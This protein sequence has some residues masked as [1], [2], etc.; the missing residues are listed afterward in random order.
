M[1]LAEAELLFT[2]AEISVALAGFSAIVV[3]FKRRDS[4]RWHAADGNRFNGMVF[5]AIFAAFFCIFPSIRGRLKSC[6][7]ADV[8]REAERLVQAGVKELLIISQ[9]TSAYGLDLK[10]ETSD[11]RGREVRIH[12]QDLAEALG[13]LGVWCT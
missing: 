3:L 4:G 13:E 2:L 9:D 7:I 11:L 12:I 5:H 6:P 1:R 10:Y 8:I